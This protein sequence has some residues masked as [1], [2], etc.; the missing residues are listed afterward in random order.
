[1]KKIVTSGQLNALPEVTVIDGMNREVMLEFCSVGSELGQY[2]VGR[3]VGERKYNCAKEVLRTD[4]NRLV[5]I[6]EG[7]G[8]DIYDIYKVIDVWFPNMT[9]REALPSE[10]V[11]Y[12]VEPSKM[13]AEQ[14]DEEKTVCLGWAIRA[15]ETCGGYGER[16]DT[17]WLTIFD[18]D[19]RMGTRD[20]KVVFVN[21]NAATCQ[22][23]Q[24]RRDNFGDG[25]FNNF[26]LV[27]M[28]KRV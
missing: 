17:V 2:T 23:K 18:T 6:R 26:K 20:E 27:R 3:A 19:L 1:M 15:K 14:S 28:F 8:T 13:V 21:K 11:F 5:I 12:T 10:G 24:M 4:D 7:G 9:W 16:Y 22:I 25:R